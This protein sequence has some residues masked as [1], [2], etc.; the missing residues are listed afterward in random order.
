MLDDD[1]IPL[2][3]LDCKNAAA[4]EQR[5]TGQA[6]SCP[7]N[8]I[9]DGCAT[10]CSR[11]TCEQAVRNNNN[12]LPPDTCEGNGKIEGGCVCPKDHFLQNGNCVLFDKCD[13]TGWSDWGQW[14]ECDDTCERG[15]IGGK[16]SRLKLRII[17]FWL[18]SRD[19][20]RRTL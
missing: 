3:D 9:F 16:R 13:E 20:I 6:P 5:I 4:L 8:R 7:E 1:R 11:M 17:T 12:L 15:T 19:K 10:E 2:I 18:F 14:S